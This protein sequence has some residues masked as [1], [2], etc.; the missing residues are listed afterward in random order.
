MGDGSNHRGG[1]NFAPDNHVAIFL[2]KYDFSERECSEGER[3]YVYKG[4]DEESLMLDELLEIIKSTITGK[5]E[6]VDI[7]CTKNKVQIKVKGCL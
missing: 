4:V 6:N 3:K 5:I 2:K 1:T 7:A